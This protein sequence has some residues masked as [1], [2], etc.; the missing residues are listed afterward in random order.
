M[1]S[2][3]NRRS[4]MGLLGGVPFVGKAIANDLVRGAGSAVPGVAPPSDDY[5]NCKTS[6]AGQAAENAVRMPRWKAARVV[7]AD[8][9]MRADFVAGLYEHHRVVHYIDPD[10][11]IMRCWSPMA[12]IA[13]QRQRNV[14]RQLEAA[15]NEPL[16]S[17]FDGLHAKISK[18]VWG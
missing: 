15:L 16:E 7:L 12:K 13:F 5:R 10:I 2:G 11:E 4:L 17:I 1:R 14:E 18:L 9:Q 8:P 6:G 3:M